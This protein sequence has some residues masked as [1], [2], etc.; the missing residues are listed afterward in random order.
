MT[1]SQLHNCPICQT[2]LTEDSE[3]CPKCNWDI[4]SESSGILQPVLEKVKEVK[5]LKRVADSREIWA[6]EIWINLTNI[7]EELVNTKTE[8][9]RLKARL[10]EQILGDETGNIRRKIEVSED[11]LTEFTD[12][13][14]EVPEIEINPDFTSQ[15]NE[16]TQ[17]IQEIQEKLPFLVENYLSELTAKSSNNN[18]S[19][20]EDLLQKIAEFVINSPE[21]TLITEN[22]NQREIT[23]QDNWKEDDFRN[24]SSTADEK[25]IAEELPQKETLNILTHGEQNLV[26]K[27]NINAKH[28]NNYIEVE[29]NPYNDEKRRSGQD[30][31][32]VFDQTNQKGNYWIVKIES[33]LYLVPRANFRANDSVITKLFDCSNFQ[34]GAGVEKLIKPGKVKQLGSSQWEFVE[35]GI[36]RLS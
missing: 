18:F 32:V 23:T 28:L 35:K 10:E 22:I 2:Q 31:P 27:Y 14:I 1:T 5:D 11:N 30:I 24:Q 36:L 4:I 7:T 13:E 26:T 6:K 34:L 20:F 3:K 21:A 16:L 9:D 25:V 12:Q 33:S 19:K 29:V 15:L 8:L 17:Q